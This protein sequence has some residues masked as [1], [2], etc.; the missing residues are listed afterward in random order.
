V[1]IVQDQQVLW[2]YES[3]RVGR[4]ENYTG[5]VYQEV[6]YPALIYRLHRQLYRRQVLTD[7]GPPAR[8]LSPYRLV[9]LPSLMMIAPDFARRLRAFVRRGGIVLAVG[10]LGMRDANANYLP[11]PGPD[12]LQSLFGVSLEGGMYLRSHVGPDEALW[13][14]QSKCR[15]LE[16][17]LAG[18]LGGAAVSGRAGKWIGDLELRGGRALLRF[19]DDAYAGQPAVVEKSTGRGRAVYAAAIHLDDALLARLVDYAL[20]LAGIPAGPPTP[21]YVEVVRRGRAVFAIN[22]RAEPVSVRLNVKG[23]ALVG[24]HRDGVA[25]LPAFGVCVVWR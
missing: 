25:E 6:N 1:A 19:E 11:Y 14:P 12:H 3:S 13:F 16:I 15:E 17:P 5:Q 7:F 22:H 18:T 9:I 24:C 10:Q 4:A 20:E 8:A 23:R 21:D 2:A